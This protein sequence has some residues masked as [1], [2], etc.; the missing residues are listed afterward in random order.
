MLDTPH[1][2][3]VI[4]EVK[5]EL[6]KLYAECAGEERRR[7]DAHVERMTRMVQLDQSDAFKSALVRVTF[8]MLAHEVR[9]V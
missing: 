3:M 9:D 2:V 7:I 6:D 8:D 1:V 5:S 4:R